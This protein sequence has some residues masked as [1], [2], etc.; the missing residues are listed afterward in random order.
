M[1]ST[2]PPF[3]T[4]TFDIPLAYPVDA[5]ET[6]SCLINSSLL[7]LWIVWHVTVLALTIVVVIVVE[8]P[9]LEAVAAPDHT[10]CRL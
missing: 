2:S 9:M 7:L 6:G 3:L 10:S 8:S 4:S 5:K 1:V